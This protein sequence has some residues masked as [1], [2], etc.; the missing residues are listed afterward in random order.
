MTAVGEVILVRT[1]LTNPPKE[2]FAVCVC[3]ARGLFFFIN[4]EPRRRKLDAQVLIHVHELGCLSHDSY[5]D[6]SQ[7]RVFRPEEM[8]TAQM[9]GNISVSIRQRVK[10][11]VLNH[12]HLP[13]GHK[14]IIEQNL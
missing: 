9:K 5:I 13:P 6:T 14:A 2:K 8:A 10:A 3:N 4:S 12:G 1:T 7:L 11:S